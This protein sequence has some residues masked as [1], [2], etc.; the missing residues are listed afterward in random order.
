[1]MKY[2]VTV[3]YNGEMKEVFTNDYLMAWDLYHYFIVAYPNDAYVD[4]IDC[5][6]G[7]VFQSS[8]DFD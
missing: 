6:T 5:S 1:M 2:E 7:E 3:R 4:I 8:Q